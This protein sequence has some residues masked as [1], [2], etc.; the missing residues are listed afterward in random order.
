MIANEYVAISRG[1]IEIAIE[2]GTKFKIGADIS[3]LEIKPG[4]YYNQY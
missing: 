3:N 1:G 4:K 2:H